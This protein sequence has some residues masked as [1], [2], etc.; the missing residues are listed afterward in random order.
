[1]AHANDDKRPDFEALTK[2]NPLAQVMEWYFEDT[3]AQ[4]VRVIVSFHAMNERTI[5]LLESQVPTPVPA[6]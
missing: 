3:V 4:I 6:G 2:K 1:M 5:K